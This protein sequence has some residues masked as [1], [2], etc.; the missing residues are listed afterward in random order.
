[1]M[2]AALASAPFT[3]G[4]QVTVT[5]EQLDEV[6]VR[7]FTP[8]PAPNTVE[9]EPT[10][11]FDRVIQQAVV[12]AAVSSAHFVWPSLSVDMV[13]LL[14]LGVGVAGFLGGDQRHGVR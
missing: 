3:G 5:G 14:E 4:T 12:H 10:L 9:P 6:L 1:M 2:S 13:L 11:G 8:V 7:A